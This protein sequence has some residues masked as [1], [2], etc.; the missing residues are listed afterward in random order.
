M[1]EIY[2]LESDCLSK[3]KTHHKFYNLCDVSNIMDV[4][5]A[6]KYANKN[7]LKVLPL[8]N[9]SNVFFKNKKIKT[10]LLRNCVSKEI[11]YL[12]EDKFFVSSSVGI[13]KLL[14]FLYKD[15]RDGPY[16]LASVPATIGGAIAMNAGTGK[17]ESRFIGDYLLEVCI[18]VNGKEQK[19][20]ACDIGL[21]YRQSIFSEQ[22]CGFIASAIFVFPKK[23]YG[24]NPIQKR[25]KW[26]NSNQDL[27]YPSCGS[28]YKVYN[29]R[30]LKWAQKF[31]FLPKT[32]FSKKA[33]N[34]IVNNSKSSLPIKILLSI[35]KLFHLIFRKN[36]SPEI[37]IVD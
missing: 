2:K 4:V 36:L 24:E 27:G 22:Y 25:L 17:K 3:Y 21:K 30:I 32:Y 10:L 19:V 37:R 34:W 35:I 5:V 1:A 12:G 29:S 28:V 26:A 13:M 33:K 16:S 14:R 8:G 11:N 9:G 15:G 18:W 6:E 23:D 31:S 20:P 7:R